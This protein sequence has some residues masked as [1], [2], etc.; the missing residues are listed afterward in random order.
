MAFPVF[1]NVY[2]THNIAF[3]NLSMQ[4]AENAALVIVPIF[5]E[6]PRNKP[7][8]ATNKWKYKVNTN[9]S[10]RSNTCIHV[11]S[12]VQPFE[13]N[14]EVSF[15]EILADARLSNKADTFVACVMF[16][17]ECRGAFQLNTV[18]TNLVK[19]VDYIIRERTR[20]NIF[21][22]YV[23]DET[24]LI[25]QA[26]GQLLHLIQSPVIRCGTTDPQ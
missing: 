10:R 25:E 22:P 1:C 18:T 16:L 21:E 11:L 7:F 13:G 23:L 19:Q 6:R 12:N 24:T 4:N 3:K 20:Q 9:F 26:K 5:E 15:A 14:V 8:L 17:V 2:E